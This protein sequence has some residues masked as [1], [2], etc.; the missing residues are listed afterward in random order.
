[1]FFPIITENTKKLPIYLT[2]IGVMAPQDSTD[3][4]AGFHNSQ[5]SVISDG[6]GFFEC[7]N[8]SFPLGKGSCF[9][10]RANLPHKYYPVSGRTFVNH[11]LT[12]DGEAAE[13]INRLIADDGFCVF[14]AAA[15]KT[16]LYEH[17]TLYRAAVENKGEE[18]LSAMLYQFIL[19]FKQAGKKEQDE[20]KR[21]K[22]APA[23]EFM[24]KHFTEDLSLD[25]LARLGG[26]SKYTFCRLFR[27][28][29]GVTPFTYMIQL[30]LQLAKQLLVTERE[31]KIADIALQ[32]GFRDV[33]YFC[34]VFK[35]Q[36]TLT[37]SEFRNF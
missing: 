37:P 18:Q 4:P 10:F 28:V 2:G 29:Q 25:E 11:W 23:L 32:A 33:S 17:E 27:E 12:F 24:D 19:N 9:F 7:G 6:T 34:S 26:M 30:R 3:R 14:S 5:L 36:E 13:Q 35:K 20:A 15:L 1:M 22:L 31:K 16:M 8:A 21:R